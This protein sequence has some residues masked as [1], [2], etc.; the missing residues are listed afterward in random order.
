MSWA[1]MPS[2][3]PGRAIL[4]RG[5]HDISPEF[6]GTTY[7]VYGF[8]HTLLHIPFLLLSRGFTRLTGIPCEGP[9][10]MLPYVFNGVLACLLLQR[11]AYRHGVPEGTA[12]WCCCRR[13]GFRM[14]PL[15]Q[16]R[17]QRVV[18]GYR[19]AGGVVLGFQSAPARRPMWRGGGYLSHGG[20][21]VGRAHRSLRS[22]RPSNANVDRSR[23]R[24]RDRPGLLEQ[25]AAD[26]GGVCVGLRHGGFQQPGVGRRLRHP[27]QRRQKRLPVFAAAA[28]GPRRPTFRVRRPGNAAA[29]AVGREPVRRPN[30]A[31]RRLV[32][33]VRRRFV[34]RAFRRPS[35]AGL[36]RGH[37]IW[38]P[39]ILA[40]VRGADRPRTVAPGAARPAPTRTPR[41][42][43]RTPAAR[44]RST[45]IREIARRSPS[46]TCATTPV[47]RR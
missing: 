4:D 37:P 29:G 21:A 10:N 17:V 15:H 5:S 8:G 25:L 14:V 45:C 11:I 1:T 13:G 41:S 38:R 46:T 30:C 42:C 44:P 40:L 19:A 18:G 43:K 3:W 34:G 24:P 20:S 47:T 39:G 9:V 33:L 31:V 7:S 22:G 16:G 12:A 27:V 32:G 26:G 35:G 23:P 28:V 2:G 6:P 36:A